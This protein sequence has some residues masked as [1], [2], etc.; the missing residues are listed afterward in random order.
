MKENASNGIWMATKG[1]NLSFTESNLQFD[2]VT[3]FEFFQVDI[4]T[5]GYGILDVAFRTNEEIWVSC[6]G[7]NLYFSVDKG[8]TWKKE[9]QVDELATNLYK[10]KFF[11]QN[12]GFILGS[13]GILLKYLS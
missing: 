13:N 5:G 1:G 8:K 2:S 6:G 12:L 7:G 3:P 4:K 9:K 11:N 10:I